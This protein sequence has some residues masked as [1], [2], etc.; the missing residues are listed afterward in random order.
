MAKRSAHG[1][2]SS[3]ADAG[4]AGPKE[5]SAEVL[6]VYQPRGEEQGDVWHPAYGTMDLPDGWAFLPRGDAFLTR[7][8][9]KGVHWVLKGRRNRKGGY[10][11]VLGVYAPEAAIEAAIAAASDT[12]QKRRRQRRS[13]IEQRVRAE[14]RYRLEFEKA[15]REFLHFTPEYQRLAEE[16]ARG[17]SEWACQVGSGR[18]A[19]T[20]KLAI[21]Q[22]VE[23]A[24]RAY[25]RHRDTRYESKLPPFFA[26]DEEEYRFVKAQ[27][28]D[29]V[30]RF[31][32]SH[33]CG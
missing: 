18:V 22:K 15:C 25:I 5:P 23:L 28:H 30:D 9:K 3:H 24:V 8:V 20:S 13:S 32:A 33:R 29:E 7:H 31:L 10:T 27:A 2:G 19:R 17:V 6:V 1:L 4:D 11:P 14:E 26:E 21:P 12:E 16:I